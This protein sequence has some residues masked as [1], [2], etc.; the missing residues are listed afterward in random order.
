MALTAATGDEFHRRAEEYLLK[1]LEKGIPSLF[2]DIKGLYVDREKMNVVESI[3]VGW[4]AKLEADEP[5]NEKDDEL[6]E[7]TTL[8]WLYY[9]LAL[10]LSHRS[11][12]SPDYQKSLSLLDRAIQ[13][14]PTLP[15]IH[16]ARAMILKRAGDPERAAREMEFARLL[17]GQDRFL[18][19]KAG[20]YWLRAGEVEK[21]TQVLGLFTKKDAISPGQD[22]RDMQ[23]NWFLIEEGNAHMRAG[24]LGPALKRYEQ[25]ISVSVSCVRVVSGES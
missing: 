18:N 20:K 5:L 24:R 15:E 7:P 10:H 12:P 22:L 8:L 16:M 2:V 11:H 9:F 1:G 4:Q 13:H 14:T 25:V 3:L 17:D 19:G 23:C 21:A 6:S